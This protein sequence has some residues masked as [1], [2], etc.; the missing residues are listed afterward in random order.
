MPPPLAIVGIARTLLYKTSF[1]GHEMKPA[2]CSKLCERP[3]LIVEDDVTLRTSLAD[4]L[5]Q[6]GY[7]VEC[8]SDGLEA[9]KR[10]CAVGAP[11][12]VILLDLMMPRL[13]GMEFQLLARSLPSAVDV[14]IVVLTGSRDYA[15]AAAG[16]AKQVFHKP[17]NTARLLTTIRSLAS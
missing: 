13:D 4:L 7:N 1:V 17:V 14:P 2:G 5:T 11:P 16:L 3:I 10:L 15:G 8:A 12:L 6:Q 9:Y